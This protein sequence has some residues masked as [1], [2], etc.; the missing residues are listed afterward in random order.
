MF[1]SWSRGMEFFNKMWLWWGFT[2][3][4]QLVI[5][6][7]I[8][9][10]LISAGSAI[11]EYNL[12][13]L[14]LLGFAFIFDIFIAIVTTWKDSVIPIFWKMGHSRPIFVYFC[15]FR[16]PQLESSHWQTFILNIYCPLYWKDEYKEKE[17]GNGPFL[18]NLAHIFR[19]RIW[20]FT[21]V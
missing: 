11:Y 9:E 14:L 6:K 13:P 19:N 10:V 20:N 3:K 4:V 15:L 16:G 7:Y 12:V 5:I 18:R 1:R 21:D 2:Q 17:V 8:F